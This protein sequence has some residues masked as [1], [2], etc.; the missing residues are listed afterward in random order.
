M[1]QVSVN[2]EFLHYGLSLDLE[3]RSAKTN[4]DSQRCLMSEGLPDNRLLARL[5]QKLQQLLETFKNSIFSLKLL[6][7]V[8]GYSLLGAW[9]FMW[10]ENSNSVE[11]KKRDFDQRLRA[12]DMLI[13]SLR[14]ISALESANLREEEW[15]K[16][17]VEFEVNL[18]VDPPDLSSQWTFSMA[19]LYAGTIY[20]TIGYG[21]V[22]CVTAA[23]RWAT[24]VYAIFGI[25]MLV[26]ILNDLSEYL[27]GKIKQL[28]VVMRKVAASIKKQW[29][30]SS[31]RK[32]PAVCRLNRNRS[33]SRSSRS[34]GISWKF[35][36]TVAKKESTSFENES[37]GEDDEDDPPY[38]MALTVCI[39]WILLSAATF[40]IWEDWTYFTSIYFFIV[41]LTTIGF[42]DITPQYP[43]YMVATFGV[44]IVGLSLV[45][46]CIN[47]VKEKLE[48]LY[49][50]LLN[51]TL[52]EYKKGLAEGDENKATRQMMANFTKSSKFLAPFISKTQGEKMM[53]NLEEKAKECGIELPPVLTE[54]NPNTG[55]PSFAGSGPKHFDEEIELAKQ[56]S[57]RRKAKENAWKAAQLTSVATQ[58]DASQQNACGV[59]VNP[60][61]A[62]KAS[63]ALDLMAGVTFDIVTIDDNAVKCNED[64]L[65]MELGEKVENIL[66]E[67]GSLREVLERTDVAVKKIDV[68][69][70]LLQTTTNSFAD[71]L[72]VL[73]TREEVRSDSSLG[74]TLQKISNDRSGHPIESSNVTSSR[75]LMQNGGLNL[76]EE[77]KHQT[78]PESSF[79]RAGI[80]AGELGGT[81]ATPFTSDRTLI[82]NKIFILQTVET[83]MSVDKLKHLECLCCGTCGSFVWKQQLE[84]GGKTDGD[85]NGINMETNDRSPSILN[86]D[87]ALETTGLELTKSDAH[88][89]IMVIVREPLNSDLT[90]SSSDKYPPQYKKYNAKQEMNDALLRLKCQCGTTPKETEL[91]SMTPSYPRESGPKDSPEG[92]DYSEAEITGNT[93]IVRDS[94][95]PG[96]TI[97]AWISRKRFSHLPNDNK[98][99]YSDD[100]R[101]DVGQ[102]KQSNTPM[103]P[104][105][106]VEEI[107]N[108]KTADFRSESDLKFRQCP[109]CRCPSFSRLSPSVSEV[110][111]GD[112]EVIGR[113]SSFAV[114]KGQSTA[115][116]SRIEVFLSGFD[117]KTK[118]AQDL[119]EPQEWSEDYNDSSRGKPQEN[120]NLTRIFIDGPDNFVAVSEKTIGNNQQVFR[121][122]REENSREKTD[123]LEVGK[124][125]FCKIPTTNVQAVQVGNE[126]NTNAND[127]Q[128]LHYTSL[129]SFYG[130]DY[131]NRHSE[132]ASSTDKY[133][134]HNDGKVVE[135]ST[136]SYTT[137][138][139]EV[140]C[141]IEI[142]VCSQDELTSSNESNDA[143]NFSC[144]SR[145]SSLSSSTSFRYA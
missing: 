97:T 5:R 46:V 138:F 63:Q 131:R 123:S 14:N 44:V 76:T 66:L 112:S 88:H 95:H 54:I 56:S 50:A 33:T 13:L 115:D 22:A 103:K 45:G 111:H 42:G 64:Q 96:K 125:V 20:T 107:T 57:L 17:M 89:V 51:R 99:L 102:G 12:R 85:N 106:V 92:C 21:N 19:L 124:R 37:A 117:R 47:L 114:P 74:R 30:R 104:T 137:Q 6:F 32:K 67:V 3:S 8:V 79:P 142:A 108:R 28:S 144:D 55:I 43:E 82:E 80:K 129:S 26:I 121:D 16:A 71:L 91:S 87:R 62:S 53:R 9:I 100:V 133:G 48:L 75:N 15:R 132:D 122:I 77:N 136:E 27:L 135:A 38:I 78:T 105:F 81:D 49:A 130:R 59:Q 23:G 145:R 31:T 58:V 25:P 139:T 118:S 128:Q 41:S 24:I 52:E 4:Q 65:L 18:G 69:R 127:D 72:G 70:E 120:K 11:Q 10:L 90:E 1:L 73:Y 68:V 83:M 61:Q 141:N 39:A 40:C 60:V 116:G 29:R 35:Y 119:S 126:S 34:G 109:L 110:R 101:T 36:T 98:E 7:I 134:S 140:E 2:N 84:S 86:I 113:S 94:S 93:V 143:T